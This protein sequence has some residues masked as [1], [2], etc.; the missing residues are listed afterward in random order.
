MPH[1]NKEEYDAYQREWYRKNRERKI[2]QVGKY[3]KSKREDR[4]AYERDY[5]A[6]KRQEVLDYYGNLCSCCGET[7]PMFLTIDH[8]NG[9]GGKHAKKVG[10]LASW[11]VRN[12]FPEGF[13]ILCMNCNHARYR[14][15]GVCPHKE[16]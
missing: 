8:I 13:Q 16:N 15:G 1:K 4:N 5:N 14:N 12:G 2:S 10:Y 11:L 3:Q 6:R 9:G 7:E